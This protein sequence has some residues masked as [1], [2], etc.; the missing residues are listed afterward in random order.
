MM[1]EPFSLEMIVEELA[2]QDA[3]FQEGLDWQQT[4]HPREAAA[5]FKRALAHY[6]DSAVVWTFY[7]WA[8]SASGDPHG[9]IA[10]CRR[11]IA[12]DAEWGPAWN[13]LGEY[14]MDT[15]REDE[16]LFVIRRA[17]KAKRFDSPH[18]AQMNLSRYYLYKGSMRRALAAAREVQRLAPG[19]RPA[20][21][22]ADWIS[23]RMREWN[24]RD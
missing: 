18:L 8:L 9:A 14:L 2:A 20:A 11:A 6:P 15:G 16:A 13:D 21:R 19:F 23:E 4:G 22:L 5:A 1:R 10:A 7:A 3:D 24:I 12:S 17:L